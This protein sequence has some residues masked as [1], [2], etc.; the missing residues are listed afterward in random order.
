MIEYPN[1]DQTSELWKQY[2]SALLD[3]HAK[4]EVNRLELFPR[5]QFRNI[6]ERYS[7]DLAYTEQDGTRV[8]E[9]LVLRGPSRQSRELI[10]LWEED[11]EGELR[12][13]APRFKKGAWKLRVIR[14]VL[15]ED[16]EVD[17]NK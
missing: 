3:R 10:R 9:Y 17:E 2:R 11:G 13:V 1:L 4:S 14:R 12:I 16:E 15:R 5:Y 6:A 8:Y 7:L